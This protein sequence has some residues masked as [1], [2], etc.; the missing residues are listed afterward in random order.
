VLAYRRVYRVTPE[1]LLASTAA[2]KA[3]RQVLPEMPAEQ[4]EVE[5]AQAIAYTAANH[6]EWFWGSRA[7]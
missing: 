2:F 5:T 3:F 6:T 7:N 1:D 4:A